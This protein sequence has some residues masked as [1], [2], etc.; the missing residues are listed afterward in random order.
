MEFDSE[1]KNSGHWSPATKAV[2]VKDEAGKSL[3]SW[4]FQPRYDVT[5]AAVFRDGFARARRVYA[6]SLNLLGEQTYMACSLMRAEVYDPATTGL[7]FRQITQSQE[8]TSRPALIGGGWDPHKDSKGQYRGEAVGSR[9]GIFIHIS[10]PGKDIECIKSLTSEI[11]SATEITKDCLTAMDLDIPPGWYAK[12]ATM[13]LNK[14]K[15][16]ASVVQ[17]DGKKPSPKINWL[18]AMWKVGSSV[19]VELTK[20]V[21]FVSTFFTLCE[22]THDEILKKVLL[23]RNEVDTEKENC[24]YAHA[25]LYGHF[26]RA[27]P[28]KEYEN[29]DQFPTEAGWQVLT[30]D[31]HLAKKEPFDASIPFGVYKL[32][33]GDMF[34]VFIE[35]NTIVQ[36]AASR[37]SEKTTEARTIKAV[38]T[39]EFINSLGRA[40]IDLSE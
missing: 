37:K 18:R 33:V 30:E 40:E 34:G 27:K 38:T 26:S 10:Y 6:R 35:Q 9:I 14:I 23:G 22:T 16:T 19:T 25:Q 12:K 20:E 4:W 1:Y 36:Q 32:R 39:V 11:N 3:A 7:V 15:L 2:R 21:P 17:H 31:G 28:I 8:P 13:I 5:S 29:Q 24:A